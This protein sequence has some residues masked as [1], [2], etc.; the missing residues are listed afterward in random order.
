M[1]EEFDAFY[2]VVDLHAITPGNHDARELRASTRSSAAI[3]LAAGLDPDKS[4]VF[5]QSHVR[6]HSEL[7]WL[8]NCATP[9]GWLEKMIQFKEKARKAGEDVSV[10][11]LVTRAHGG[12]HSAVQRGRGARRGGPATAPR[13]HARHRRA[14]EQPVRRGKWKKMGPKGSRAPS[15]RFRGQI[16]KVPEAYIPE[17][18]ARVMSLTDG[19]AKMSKSNPAEGSGINVLDTPTRSR[20]RSNDARRTRSRGWSSITRIDRRRR[21]S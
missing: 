13:T 10:G 21:T 16:L 2:C 9:I 4:N 3:Y 7:C 18:G 8:L 17:A 15:G 5:V 12:G 6:A 14:R 19:T 11:L 1:Q 20:R